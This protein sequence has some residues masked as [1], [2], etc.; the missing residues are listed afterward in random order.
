MSD[1]SKNQYRLLKQLNN[2]KHI[3]YSQISKE[4]VSDYEYLQ[5]QG[6]VE[7]KLKTIFKES[8]SWPNFYH[9]RTEVCI[10][11]DGEAFIDERS[12]STF[13]FYLPFVV[14]TFLSLIAIGISIL[15]LIV[16]ILALK[17]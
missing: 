17:G 11:P 8:D 16:S 6:F 15:A 3:P 4:D 13:R 1:L 14:S 12:K 5:D 9:K 7:I 2:A 10:L